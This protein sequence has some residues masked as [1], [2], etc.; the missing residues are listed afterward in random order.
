MKHF[1]RLSNSARYQSSIISLQLVLLFYPSPSV[2]LSTPQHHHNK[3]SGFKTR[4]PSLRGQ[5]VPVL[6]QYPLALSKLVGGQ[7]PSQIAGLLPA[8]TDNRRG[9]G[10]LE[11]PDYM[12]QIFDLR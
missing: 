6:H 12:I 8:R 11:A 7:I 10:T 3:L 9:S 1:E 4:Y 5:S 2:F